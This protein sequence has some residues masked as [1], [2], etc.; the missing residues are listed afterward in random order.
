MQKVLLSLMLLAALLADLTV[1]AKAEPISPQQAKTV[2]TTFL[3]GQNI[4]VKELTDI[5]SSTSFTEFYVL[6]LNGT[7]FILVSADDVATPILAYS[8]TNAFAVKGMPEH[9]RHW[10]AHYDEEIA[11]L[12]EHGATS[13]P[14]WAIMLNG[15]MPPA[16][17]DT[18]VSPLMTTTWNQ[19]P[20]Y[21]SL[22]PYDS[23]A[24]GYSVTGCV[25]TATAQIMKFWNFPTTGYGS[26]NYTHDN[27][28]TLGA[29]FGNT[30]YQWSQMPNAL[31]Y[32]STT[33]QVN[34]VATL[35][36]HI[37]VANEMYYGVNA[38]GAVTM[39]AGN[40]YFYPASNF[41]LINYF[42]YCPDMSVVNGGSPR[43]EETLAAEMSAGRPVLFSG[44][45]TSGGHAF[46]LDGCNANGQFH[47]NWGWGGYCDGYY[48][49]GSLNPAAG[50][51]GGN[52]TYTFN[53]KNQAL[54]GIRPN[55]SFGS[56]TT[57]T[58]YSGIHG[59]ATGSGTYAFNDT[60]SL[61][62]Y[63]D[64]GYVV[65]GWSDNCPTAD[66]SF[67]AK[68]G[69]YSYTV[70]Q[71][72]LSGDTLGYCFDDW[73][74][75][76]SATNWGIKLPA[77][78]LDANKTLQKV[79]VHSYNAG[80][81]TL[82]IYV[83]DS[84]ASSLVYTQTMAVDSACWNTFVLDSALAVDATQ[85]MWITF[86]S[87]DCRFPCVVSRG[88]GSSDGFLYGSHF[89]E[90]YG[91]GYHYACM[92]RGIFGDGDL[93]LAPNVVVSN[94]D[95]QRIAT[96][97]AQASYTITPNASCTEYDVFLLSSYIYD[98][99]M[100]YVP[101][102]GNKVI[103]M[104]G[105]SPTH[106]ATTTQ[107]FTEALALSSKYYLY[108]VAKGATDSTYVI[109][110]ISTPMGGG[111]GLAK[112]ALNYYEVNDS[113]AYYHTTM[114]DQT[115][116][117]YV[118][119]QYGY[120]DSLSVT[121]SARIVNYCLQNLTR[122]ASNIS[123]S[124]A[125]LSA[126]D[127][128]STWVVPFN[129]LS[130]VGEMTYQIIVIGQGVIAPVDPCSEPIEAM[131]DNVT[132]TTISIS[133]NAVS[134]TTS[135]AVS[136]AP[137]TH[138][139]LDSL[140]WTATSVSSPQLSLT[141]LTPST[142][143][144]FTITP[145]SCAD[146]TYQFYFRTECTLFD[147]PY[148]NAFDVPT[149][150]HQPCWTLHGSFYYWF[151][152]GTGLKWPG[153]AHGDP[154]LA[155]MPL[156]DTVAYPSVSALRLK[157]DL[158]SPNAGNY[159]IAGIMS[160]PADTTTFVAIGRAE[161]PTRGFE[162]ATFDFASYTG[163][164][165]YVAFRLTG[166]NGVIFD[167]ILLEE[168]PTCTEIT[169]LTVSN[170]TKNSANLQWNA[171]NTASS[172]MILYKT[173]DANMWDTLSLAHTDTIA[174]L[175][176]LL[177]NTA[178]DVAVISNCSG[179][180]S[181]PVSATLHTK[182]DNVS[183][184]YSVDFADDADLTHQYCWTLHGNFTIWHND[185]TYW[186]GTFGLP[187]YAVLPM[188]DTVAN[189]NV[190]QL[191]LEMTVTSIDTGN[192]LVV[193]VM[194]DPNDT[195]T[196]I[197]V[198]RIEATTNEFMPV[199]VRLDRY[200]N[201]GR[202]V[203]FKTL[204]SNGIIFDSVTLRP[205]CFATVMESIVA[206]DHYLWRDGSEHYVS[207]T[208]LDTVETTRGCD[209]IF[210]L[211]LTINHST[212]STDVQTVCDSYTWIDG[213]TYTD[214][215]ST[216]THTLAN[217]AGC[218]S[219]VTL[220]L[221][222]SH[223][224]A[225]TDV[226]TACDSYTWIDGNTYTDSDSTAT[227]TLANAAGC[228]S[229]V[230]LLLTINVSSQSS[231]SDSICKGNSYEFGGMDISASGIYND[232][233]TNASGC[234]SILTLTLTVSAVYADTITAE[235]H[236]GETYNEHGFNESEAGTY[237]HNLQ[238]TEGCDST[239][240]LVLTMNAGINADAENSGIG[241]FPNPTTGIVHI[242]AEEVLMVEVVDMSGRKVRSFAHTGTVDM[243]DLPVGSYMMRISTSQGIAVRKVVK[244]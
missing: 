188:Y 154:A 200:A 175:T 43:F 40:D 57:V 237:V 9:V 30:S 85:P 130:Q 51:A 102:Y 165:H 160:D 92:I 42:K 90:L 116:Y 17:F 44:R 181:T 46:V 67:L 214:S 54:I 106:T 45:D 7:G 187:A 12:K 71:E 140:C 63:A 153:S 50:G 208:L 218:D 65:T 129:Q 139:N 77:A 120:L 205:N 169:S 14:Y 171:S 86:H 164:G 64:E 222:V 166:D 228:D 225:S 189:P 56:S 125:G 151:N 170:V 117:Y 213:N 112:V 172:Y 138:H 212:A 174:S 34:A 191:Q 226:Q 157:V 203:A 89:D 194:S 58:V 59:N 84:S 133:W 31:N 239:I 99:I 236:D 24:G 115:A 132:S 80:T 8:V 148:A 240:V 233:L 35:M 27:F 220:H 107:T 52:A 241:L 53:L 127:T 126:G 37:G 25:A 20:Y 21:N 6:T 186:P 147:L 229:T 4:A 78:V 39:S 136:Y 15:E 185:I 122:H 158:K 13:H 83:G 155:V 150:Y 167:N 199:K 72:M 135:Y 5:T 131:M 142:E 198:E 128:I 177:T 119:A 94:I 234:D 70:S 224:T 110:S 123:R 88:K 152:N 134:G 118:Y 10:L 93:P 47:V 32:S 26:H 60:I 68:G 28:G 201:N 178:Y 2:A 38:S 215:D 108:I 69:S 3:Q 18:P 184:P 137:Y 182:C 96:D 156:Y 210:T 211:T 217:A 1:P 231:I 66:R 227:H 95:T 204:G 19:S 36:Y 41:S 29:N 196:F 75:A 61:S 149:M 82:N 74:D 176:N 197:E 55:N 145:S 230:T 98:Y 105:L 216:A 113:V 76:Y 11:S 22:C 16:T 244:K 209:S 97:Y 219:T 81:Y 223:S 49:I 243:S 33:A 73:W 62:A 202:Y 232:T 162:T 193:G 146:T 235:I 242:D 143:Y 87:T 121:D 104:V 221:T 48:A 159:F 168:T 183:L 144:I 23:I 206:C 180:T 179:T 190:A 109:D 207:G 124:F 163:T 161:A 173:T 91:S 103:Y 100:G 141:G 111:T 79:M 114:N 195:S 192:Y 101:T 238:T